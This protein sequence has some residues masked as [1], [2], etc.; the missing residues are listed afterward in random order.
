MG[1]RFTGLWCLRHFTGQKQCCGKGDNCNHDREVAF[2]FFRRTHDGLELD[3]VHVLLVAVLV[4]DLEEGVA[5][6]ARGGLVRPG[7]NELKARHRP[8]ELAV[9]TEVLAH[10]APN[11]PL[12]PRALL[13]GI[14]GALGKRELNGI[15]SRG[16]TDKGNDAR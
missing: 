1:F 5:A 7:S 13:R 12:S 9:V 2:K 8:R 15:E 16:R 14:A 11:H 10:G 4:A 6:A 3:P